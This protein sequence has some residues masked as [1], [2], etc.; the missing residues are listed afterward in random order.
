MYRSLTQSDSA[1]PQGQGHRPDCS[2][3]QA[4]LLRADKLHVARLLAATHLQGHRPGSRQQLPHLQ[5]MP[6]GLPSLQEPPHELP[7]LLLPLLPPQPPTG[8][9][10]NVFAFPA[11]ARGAA[12]RRAPH[13]LQVS[14]LAEAKGDE[15]L[16]QPLQAVHVAMSRLLG[17]VRLQGGGRGLWL[18]TW[19]HAGLR[20][21]H[22]GHADCHAQRALS[23]GERTWP[24]PPAGVRLAARPGTAPP[25]ASLIMS[26]A[27]RQSEHG[28]PAERHAQQ[29]MWVL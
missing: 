26:Q 24:C 2:S 27:A 1:A 12:Q 6:A 11:M 14:G 8:R 4:L 22:C 20:S 15:R 23:L 19:S 21:D 16:V 5:H 25:A 7:S 10:W 13:L 9:A 18:E 29:A 3:H 17:C 28:S